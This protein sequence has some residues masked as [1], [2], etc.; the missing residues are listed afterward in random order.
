MKLLALVLILTFFIPI[1]AFAAMC[2]PSTSTPTA[3]KDFSELVCIGVNIIGQLVP[4]LVGLSLVV[5][6]WGLTM[7]IRASGDEAEIKKGKDMMIY[8]IMGLFIMVSVWGIIQIMFTSVF[9][10][11]PFSF[12]PKLPE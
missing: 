11:A 10:D 5:L 8:G 1:P 7:F 12:P 9:G 4:F 2:A 6:L 3:P